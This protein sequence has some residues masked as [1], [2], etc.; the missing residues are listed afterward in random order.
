MPYA[1]PLKLAFPT[2]FSVCSFLPVSAWAEGNIT[3]YLTPYAQLRYR[4]EQVDQ[5][6]KAKDADAST[7]R[8]KLGIKT[9]PY[10]GLSLTLEGLNVSRLGPEHFDDT[11]HSKTQYP[12][13]ADPN[14]T[15]LNQLFIDWN[16][17]YKSNLRFG[18]Q[19]I[20]YDNQRFVGAS[21]WRQNDQT[22]DGGKI[23]IAAID[24]LAAS[25]VY[26]THIQRVFGTESSVGDWH[27]HSHLLNLTY[28][29]GAYGKLTGYGYL[30]DL[31]DS[32]TLSSKTFGL[33]YTG[34]YTVDEAS[35]LALTWELEGAHQS[36]YG[37]N[38][39]RFSLNYWLVQPGFQW[40]RFAFS[41]AVE[42]LGSD[43]IHAFQTP[44]ATL[45]A[46]NGWA[47][48]FTTTPANGLQDNSVQA[49]VALP[50]PAWLEKAQA[51]GQWHDFNAEN[52]SQNYGHEIDL[53]LKVNF[54]SHYEAGLKLARYNAQ[55][56][57]TDTDK[58]MVWL[59][60]NY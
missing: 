39:N 20:N 35:K 10:E 44:L 31:D 28:D 24:H 27:T 1:A 48:K 33:R 45:H 55:H 49:S 52:I 32:D 5:D 36:D 58:A 6:G 13:V 53:M 16:G 50:V 4:F 47:D 30:L 8:T 29:G 7:L 18:R 43:G 59:S 14:G 3:N 41:A 19:I 37:E 40:G 51:I 21:D 38:P 22:F 17:P 46:F 2:I 12:I 42:T 56:F 9:K 34:K 26:L 60:A 11:V 57:A 15:R 23:D 54:L 25:Y